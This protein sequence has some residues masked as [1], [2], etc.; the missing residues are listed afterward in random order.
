M[1][2]SNLREDGMSANESDA[3][4]AVSATQD[5]SKVPY[6]VRGASEQKMHFGFGWQLATCSAP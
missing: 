6:G 2:Y 1:F 5:P 3:S 4:R